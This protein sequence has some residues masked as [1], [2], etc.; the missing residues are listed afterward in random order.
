MPAQ[1]QAVDVGCYTTPMLKFI[2]T[3]LLTFILLTTF[4][5]TDRKV[6]TYLSAQFDNTLYDKTKGNNPWGIGLGL[7]SRLNTSTRFKPT[8]ELTADIY[9]EDDKTLTTI[10]DIPL[11]DVRH[12]VNLFAGSAFKVTKELSVSF[13]AGPSFIGGQTFVGIKPSVEVFFS[14]NNRLTAKAY[15]INIFYREK[16]TS[17][18]FGSVG[19][20]F[21]I[22]LF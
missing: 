14:K 10:N 9:L 3:S 2:T 16:I 19:L 1:Q 18:D 17:S 7:Q 6:T 22:K 12:M 11:Q 13:T 8:I 4:A 20:A 15:Y 21:G 5:Q